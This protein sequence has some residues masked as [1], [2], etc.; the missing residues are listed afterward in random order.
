[1]G[2]SLVT[3]RNES[4]TVTILSGTENGKTL[5]TPLAMMV[6]NQDQRKFDY[7]TTDTIPRPG[8][9][10]FTYQIKYGTRASSGG[11]RSSARETIGRVAAGAIAEKWLAET[12][13][14]KISCWVRSVGNIRVPDDAVPPNGWMREEVDKLGTFEI[15]SGLNFS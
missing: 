10:D 11:G 3:P 13:G 2:S 1:M 9:A 6:R 12:Y 14:T 8:H 15:R 5:G 4:D 7:A